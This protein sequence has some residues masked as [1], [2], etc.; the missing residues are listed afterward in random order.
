[1]ANGSALVPQ[2]LFDGTRYFIPREMPFFTP[3][4]NR[5]AGETGSYEYPVEVSNKQMIE[6]RLI[7]FEET[8]RLLGGLSPNTV[9]QRKGGTQELTHVAGFGRRVMLIREE[10][11]DLIELRIAQARGAERNRRNVLRVVS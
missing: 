8:S 2:P 4:K 9:R 1:M 3:D 11:E 5:A 6:S 10:V 7:S